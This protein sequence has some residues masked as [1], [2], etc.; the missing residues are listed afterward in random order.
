MI[1]L[2]LFDID[3]TLILTGGAGVRGMTR[4]FEDLFGVP[5]GFA[6]IEVPGRTD[7]LIL[8]DA[9]ARLGLRLTPDRLERFRTAYVAHLR[10]EIRHARPGKRVMPGV[11]PLLHA[12][13]RQTPA[14][15]ALLTGNFADAARVKLEHFGLWH[16]FRCGA[17][18]DDA[19]ERND[20]VQ[21]VIGRA[22][23]CGLPPVSAR[24]VLVIGDTPLD[25]ACAAAAGARAVAVATGSHSVE[26]L[27]ATG[28]D[29]VLDDLSDTGGVMRFLEDPAGVR[30]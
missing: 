14:L 22:R 26:E 30:S 23:A 2:V 17:F 1:R 16:H 7:Q 11:V 15:P 10:E 9:L 28:A 27:R 6:G 24:E 4:A 3:G 19:L 25:V 12:V 20:L 18:A 13:T 8:R 5:D 29:L 21:V